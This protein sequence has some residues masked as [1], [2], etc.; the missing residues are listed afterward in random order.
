MELKMNK[1]RIPLIIENQSTGPT[2]AY[3]ENESPWTRLKVVSDEVS[4]GIED[5]IK[6]FTNIFNNPSFLKLMIYKKDEITLFSSN[7]KSG[8]LEISNELQRLKSQH[9]HRTGGFNSPNDYQ[10]AL[11][12]NSKYVELGEKVATFSTN[13]FIIIEKWLKEQ[14]EKDANV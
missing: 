6:E 1:K 12:I 3:G 8:L 14:E 11:H 4:S 7:F 10:L 13:N 9:Y 2:F 5:L